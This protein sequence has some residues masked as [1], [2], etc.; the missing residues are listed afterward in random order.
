MSVYLDDIPLTGSFTLP[1][2]LL[3]LTSAALWRGSTGTQFGRAGEAGTL[4]LISDNFASEARADGGNYDARTFAGSLHSSSQPLDAQFAAAVGTRD[5]YIRNTLLEHYVDDQHTVDLSGRIRWSA[6][7]SAQFTL[8]GLA[9]RERDG[10]QPLVPLKGP[11]FAVARPIDGSTDIDTRGIALK[12]VFQ[13][14]WGLLSSTTSH[15]TYS[16]DPYHNYLVLPP[17]IDSRLGQE[18]RAWNEE[19]RLSADTPYDGFDWSLGA[20]LSDARTGGH[21][22]RTIGGA[23]TYELSDFDFHAKTGALFGQAQYVLAERW[24][25]EAGLRVERLDKSFKRVNELASSGFS[26]S[27]SNDFALPRL[28]LAYAWSSRTTTTVTVSQAARPG[29]WSG[30]TDDARLARFSPERADELEVDT[31][32]RSAD[33][34]WSLGVR[35]FVY[36]V[37]DL[38]IERSFSPADYLVANA[39]RARS[40]G[41]ELE[42]AWRAT[43]AWHFSIAAGGSQ[44]KLL[45]FVNPL[46]GVSE[47]GGPVPY[48]PAFTSDLSASYQHD[49]FFAVAQ[50]LSTGR[51][52]FEE[53][54]NP[55]FTQEAHSVL[56]ARVGYQTRAWRLAGYAQNLTDEGYYTLI[57]PG[58]VHGVPGAPRTF[59]LELA[60]TIG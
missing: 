47:A 53:T 49:G 42:L 19:M 50:L 24:S 26:D 52:D 7:E 34:R 60:A 39:Q 31:R 59:G 36:L 8:E 55:V 17:A 9:T 20:W 33:D 16:L 14:R 13:T 22:D 11:L 1:T 12:G 32:S 27:R 40:V 23:F 56:N 30:Y 15:T 58:V 57:I 44:A 45:K 48:S 10:A 4:V 54:E 46:T 38:Q 28:A 29:G 43:D 41:E 37:R 6:A 21:T 18:Q 35:G 51:T 5:G 3:G 2:R 25:L